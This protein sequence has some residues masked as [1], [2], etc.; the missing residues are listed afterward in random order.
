MECVPTPGPGDCDQVT[1]CP[2]Q[3]VC[4]A[5]RNGGPPSCQAGSLP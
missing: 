2:L 5:P 3:Q 1:D 4:A